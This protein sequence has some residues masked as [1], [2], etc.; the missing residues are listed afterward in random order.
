MINFG[1]VDDNIG[2]FA[3]ANKIRAALPCGIT[4]LLMDPLPTETYRLFEL[5]KKYVTELLHN[6]CDAA[7]IS[8]IAL[9]N[10]CGRPLSA[11]GLPV[12]YCEAPVLHAA[13]YTA[14]RVLIAGRGYLRKSDPQNVILC[15]MADFCTLAEQ[16]N[17]RKIVEYI[18]DCCE[19]YCG[20][21]DCIAL[22]H[23]SMNL[24]KR[25]FR[26]VFPNVQVFDSVDGVARRIRKKYRKLCKDEGVFGVVNSRFE[27]ISEKFKQ[28]IE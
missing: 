17:E 2:G 28:F 26:R 25:C 24:Y 9:S 7:V 8:N 20:S 15:E 11:I 19:Q 16:G 5:G 6:G 22:A 12:F 18:A 4:C 14:S 27:D 13:T 3:V 21:F 1:I 23:S 10:A